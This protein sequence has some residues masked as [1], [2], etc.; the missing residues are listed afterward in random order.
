M[1]LLTDMS[2]CDFPAASG[3]CHFLENELK[4][5]TFAKN[6]VGNVILLL[7][8]YSLFDHL[9]TFDA[10]FAFVFSFEKIFSISVAVVGA[11]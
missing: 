6:C 11:P 3:Q 4:N 9:F 5:L 10:V 2:W 7:I 1:I 8:P